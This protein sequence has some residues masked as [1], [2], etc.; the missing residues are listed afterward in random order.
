[1]PSFRRTLFGA[2]WIGMRFFMNFLIIYK[3]SNEKLESFSCSWINNGLQNQLLLI[4]SAGKACTKCG[5]SSNSVSTSNA[6][7][8]LALQSVWC[9]RVSV[10]INITNATK[11]VLD[12]I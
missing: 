5:S 11:V 7:V 1:M 9:H 3:I 10:V 2:I 8:V 12:F 4:W 6:A